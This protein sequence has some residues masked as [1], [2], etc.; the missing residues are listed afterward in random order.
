[1]PLRIWPKIGPDEAAGSANAIFVGFAI[2]SY[3]VATSA[4]A[5]QHTRGLGGVSQESISEHFV[6][7]FILCGNVGPVQNMLLEVSK[8][9]S[10]DETVGQ[11]CHRAETMIHSW[12]KRRQPM[13]TKNYDEGPAALR[14]FTSAMRA[15][16]RVPKEAVAEPKVKHVR[17]GRPRTKFSRG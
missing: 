5:F 17:R 14:N 10:R 7:D 1:M 3:S 2:E 4:I 16:F 15:L 13:K 8:P 12:L 11:E 9:L 6:S